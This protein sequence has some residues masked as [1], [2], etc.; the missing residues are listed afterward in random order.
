MVL[1]YMKNEPSCSLK[2][3]MYFFT[4][5]ITFFTFFWFKKNVRVKVVFRSKS[6]MQ[7]T[8]SEDDVSNHCD[9]TRS[10]YDVTNIRNDVIRR[11]SHGNTSS[12][13][14]TFHRST[15][16]ITNSSSSESDSHYG[17]WDATSFRWK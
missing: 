10:S 3:L 8:K 7:R 16:D 12:K 11:M 6:K 4:I 5:L 2:F 14:V 9:V 13:K 15:K 1:F 17:K